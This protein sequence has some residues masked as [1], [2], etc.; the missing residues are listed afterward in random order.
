MTASNQPV[1]DVPGGTTVKYVGI[2]DA[3]SGGNFMGSADV[4]DETFANQGT[5]T[6]TS[7]QIDLNA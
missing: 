5:Y 3:Q 2:W 4:T 6:V 7:A 1:F